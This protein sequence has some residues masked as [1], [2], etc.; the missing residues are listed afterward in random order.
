MTE[1]APVVTGLGV[2]A[3]NGLGVAAYWAANLRGEPGIGPR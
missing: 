1:T 2:V 3:P